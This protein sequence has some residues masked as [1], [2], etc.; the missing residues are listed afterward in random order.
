MLRSY[1]TITFR[2]FAK[3][4]VFSAI[5]IL[6]LA[7][8]ITCFT[9][10]LLFVEREFSYDRFHRDP[11]NVYRVVKDFVN[12]DGTEIP[13]ATVPPALAYAIRRELPEVE[14]VTR[15]M[16]NGG[17]RNLFEYGDKRFY[18]L[19]LLRI[20]SSFFHVFDFRFVRGSKDRPFNGTHT[21]ILTETAARKYF[22]D[23]NPIG[24]TIRTNINNQ[25]TFEVTGVLEDVPENSHFTFDVLIPFESRRDPDTNWT[26]HVF[27]T[28]ARL[29]A[30]SNAT[31]F[32]SKVQ[33]I[34]K[35]HLPDNL[36]RYYVQSLTDIHLTS[37]LKGELGQNGDIQYVR[38]LLIIGIFVLVIAG[39]NYVNLVTAQS[40]KRAREIGVRKVTGAFRGLLIGQFLF[41][42]VVMV[43]VASLLAFI[44]TS[45]FLP[46]TRQ[47]FGSDLTTFFS[48]S[49]SIRTILPC[50][51]LAIGILSGIYPALYLSS[52]QPL[53]VLR[54]KFFSSGP[55][56]RLRQGLVV[57]Q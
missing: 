56:I 43:L 22:G 48:E 28:Y 19:N 1:L 7:I 45:L 39:I 2:N 15:F 4:K 40:A 24:K 20:D 53:K 57:F 27:Y 44:L 55:G 21:I 31:A 32:E 38:I 37:R 10:I 25:T 5:N 50:S 34:V 23:E 30:S 6:G 11:K 46:S 54:G 16:A 47:I 18:E 3:D 13:D 42:S 35:K 8:G 26:S 9:I 29:K 49:N 33:E 14:S 41:E 12:K 17:R 36:D 51:I 52:F